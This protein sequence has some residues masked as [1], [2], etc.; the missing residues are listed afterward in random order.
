VTAV[1][2]AEAASPAELEDD[3]VVGLAALSK[4][5]F[6]GDDLQPLW[7]EL[8]ARAGAVPPNP[9]ALM[10]AATLLLLTGDRENGLGLQRQALDLQRVYRRRA[11]R[12]GGVRLL[13]VMAA[14]DAMANTPLDF[15]LD[16]SDV[17]LLSLFVE[18]G[19]PIGPLP[20]HDAAF[21]AVGESAENLPV[22][23]SLTQAMAQWP[24]PVLN[25]P[26]EHIARLTRDGVC[27]LAA[28]LPQVLAPATARLNR[29]QLEQ[30]ASGAAP[31]GAFLAGASFP[32]IARPIGSH[33]GAGLLK[34]DQAVDVAAYVAAQTAERFYVSPFVDYSSP[35]GLFRKQRIVLIEG[36]PFVCH[37]AVSG[38]WMV[39]YL[40]ADML[41]NPQNRAEEARFMAGFDEDFAVRHRT[42]FEGLAQRVGLDYF[43]IDC[44]ET[45]DGRLLLFE[46]DVAMI[47]HNMDPVDTFPYKPL[48]MH[49]VFDAFV[50]MLERRAGR[51]V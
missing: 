50:A 37:L 5:V 8:V 26:P 34:L 40:N 36:R 14:G 19:V 51:S 41:E 21:L 30:I 4:M 44:A 18:P 33:A 27:A 48:Q 47:V 2:G 6:A 15:L 9:S 29:G 43:G 16:G 11:Q 42:A 10:D 35:D 1:S 7:A 38:H 31:L 24:R 12:P 13:A 25:G 20:D 28:D 3:G 32:I 23:R 17:E 39:H 46:A 45:K 49:K 22:L